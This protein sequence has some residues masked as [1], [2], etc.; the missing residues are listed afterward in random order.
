MEQF[1]KKNSAINIVRG[2]VQSAEVFLHYCTAEGKVNE[3]AYKAN[4]ILVF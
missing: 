4:I 1:I 2:I 3:G